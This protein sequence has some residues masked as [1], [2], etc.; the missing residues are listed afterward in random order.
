MGNIVITLTVCRCPGPRI[1]IVYRACRDKPGSFW[2]ADG[3]GQI[4]QLEYF[5]QAP[6][7]PSTPAGP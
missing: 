7:C 5:F 1:E 3:S 2:V 4:V 6:Y